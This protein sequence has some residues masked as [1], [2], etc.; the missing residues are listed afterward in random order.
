MRVC[1]VQN[2]AAVAILVASRPALAEERGTI[3]VVL[4]QE[5][6]ETESNHRGPLVAS[7]VIEG[8]P[9]AKAGL[10]CG[11]RILAVDR[12]SVVGRELA[13]IIKND[14]RGPSGGKVQLTVLRADGTQSEITLERAAYPPRVNPESDPFAYRVPGGWGADSRYPFPL[15]WA[16]RLAYRGFEDL[17]FLPNFDDTNSPEY[18]SYVFFLWV[19]GTLTLSAKQLEADMRVYFRGLA[20]E[21]GRHYRFT[22][23]LSKVTASYAADRSAPG[24][25][26][27]ATARGF[28][29]T[30]TIWDTHGKLIVLNS[31]VISAA[32]PG[33]NHTALFFGMSLE[34]RNGD[35]WRQID[36]VR[37]SFRCKR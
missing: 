27:G 15:P 6:S 3:G 18:H 31:E 25:F 4:L 37:D 32:C 14:L 24:T 22:P 20:E 2:L 5:F 13:E 36:A 19:E 33:S 26:G 28:R 17:F 21:R 11:D 10:R 34:P 23:D 8:S 29:G 35:V 12:K 9:A 7:G 16:P 30:V 1:R